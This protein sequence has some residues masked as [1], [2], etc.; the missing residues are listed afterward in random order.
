MNMKKTV[1]ATSVVAV[2]GTVSSYSAHAFSVGT[3]DTL[4][5]TAGGADIVAYYGT[6]NN[7]T[8]GSY[9]GMD[10]SGDSKIQG[11]EKV[12]LSQGTSGLVIGQTTPQGSYHPG[13]PTTGDT[14]T[15]DAPWNFFGNTGTD[16]LSSAVTGDTTSGLNMSGWTVSWATLSSIPMGAG[17]WTVG[18]CGL[19]GCNN[20]LMSEGTAEFNWNGVDGGAYYLNYAG[21]VPAG[22]PSGFGGVQ[23]YLH[24]EGNVTVAAVPVP[25]A[26]WLFGSGLVGLVGVARRKQK[27]V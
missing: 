1:L 25:A 23:Y 11:T 27:Q 12:P 24:L 4:S 15:I 2:M 20:A 26:V 8:S 7:V 5:I 10:T 6:I 17:T 22:D 18:N 14:G 3:N 9:F 21:T 16:W 13:A 19:L